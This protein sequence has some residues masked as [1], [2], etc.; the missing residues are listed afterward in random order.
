MI[1]KELQ[2]LGSPP[3]QLSSQLYYHDDDNSDNSDDQDV[4]ND[5]NDDYDDENHD[6]Y[7]DHCYV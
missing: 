6:D 5:S 2:L 1:D 3:H 4:N 7:D